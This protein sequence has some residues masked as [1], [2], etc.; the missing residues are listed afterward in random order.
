MRPYH[1]I[2]IIECGEPLVKIPLERF[3]VE[4]PHPYEKLGA[5]YGGY[6][7]YFLRASVVENLI[8][9]QNYL[10]L[11]H[12]GWYIQ[13]F[14]A[15]RPVAVQQ[16][17]VDYSFAQ[18]VQA[19]GL[20]E[21]DLSTQ[22]REEIWQQVYEIWAVP[23]LDMNT[24]PPHSTGAAV[25]ITLVNENGEVVNMGSPIDEMSER[26][27]PDYYAHSDAHRH[28]EYHHHRELLLNVML[29]AGF[30]RNPREW[31]HF[32]FGDQMWAWLCNQPTARYGRFHNE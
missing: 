1:Q 26:S 24:P 3:A 8:E 20:I 4:T 12:P 25:D 17:M 32:S 5:D 13:I 2:S 28:Q 21:S 23:S 16:F 27:H 7:A 9:A 19:R 29:K 14:D 11:L 18:A 10:Q 30:Q 22:Q 31:W 6:S 15:Y